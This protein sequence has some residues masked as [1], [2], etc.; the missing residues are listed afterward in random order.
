MNWEKWGVAEQTRILLVRN[1]A[2]HCQSALAIKSQ[3]EMEV[4]WKP[5]SFVIHKVA[6][7]TNEGRLFEE[8]VQPKGTFPEELNAGS[9]FAVHW[10]WLGRDICC[11]MYRSCSLSSTPFGRCF[12]FPFKCKNSWISPC[13]N[14]FR[15]P[16][17]DK[18]KIL[19]FPLMHSAMALRKKY[20]TRQQRPE[21]PNSLTFPENVC[22]N[23]P[24]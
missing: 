17:A 12:F 18:Q 6:M 24:V 20:I 7:T 21:S 15:F 14:C 13:K 9:G 19:F 5:I 8:E 23:N 1:S 16:T 2:T 3:M 4:W 22:F 10:N 11:E